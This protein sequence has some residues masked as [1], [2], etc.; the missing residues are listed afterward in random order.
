MEKSKVSC[1]ISNSS[2][3]GKMVYIHIKLM[4]LYF[5][6]FMSMK[7]TSAPTYSRIRLSPLKTSSLSNRVLS[8]TLMSS[9]RLPPS[10]ALNNLSLSL[11]PALLKLGTERMWA[12]ASTILPR[13]QLELT[14]TPE[15]GLDVVLGGVTL[16]NVLEKNLDDDYLTM[17]YALS[18]CGSDLLPLL[19][20]FSFINWTLAA[21][22]WAFTLLNFF[23]FASS[24]LFSISWR[25]FGLI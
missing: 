18:S 16:V 12:T 19:F 15:Q 20:I 22:F 4:S 17:K 23:G 25:K 5:D 21:V 8:T 3:P 10:T 7:L 11:W 1:V 24:L 6:H 9:Q 13:L 14:Q 2:S